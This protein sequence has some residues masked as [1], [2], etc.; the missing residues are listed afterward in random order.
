MIRRDVIAGGSY[1]EAFPDG[2]YYVLVGHD[3]VR[4][5]GEVVV[6]P[7]GADKPLYLRA[8]PSGQFAGQGHLSG[9]VIRY[10]N[11][12]WI[13]EGT[14]C[15]VNPVCF[16]P[17]GQLIVNTDCAMGTQGIRWIDPN[18]TLHS[19]DATYNGIGTTGVAEWTQLGNVVV[20]QSYVDGC[21]I[22]RVGDAPRT[23]EPG[24]CTFVRFNRVGSQL[25]VALWKQLENCA[26]LFWLDEADIATL[27]LEPTTTPQPQPEPEPD[28]Q[29]EPE[30]P[31]PPDNGVVNGVLV[32]PEHYFLTLV[33]GTRP[34]D[35]RTVLAQIEPALN[36]YGIGQ[37]KS[38]GGEPRGRLYLPTAI[39]PNAKPT[40]PQEQH[41]GVKQDPR[42]WEAQGRAVNVVAPDASQWIWQD[43]GGPAYQPIGTVPQPD[44][45]PQPQP[46][47]NPDLKV[48]RE[49][50]RSFKLDTNGH[51]DDLAVAIDDLVRRIT[52]LEQKPP[53]SLPADIVRE[54]THK[55]RVGPV[56]VF[57]VNAGTYDGTLV[58]K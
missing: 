43:M 47:P 38:S 20:G 36:L 29:P 2:S 25:A 32:N 28:P 42:C 48:L 10:Q 46:D 54:T 57:G 34:Q 44:P 13:A 26:V 45:N 22:R 51:F 49:E 53:Q 14:T 3:V 33:A 4:A 27:P 24:H 17:A 55:V 21:T 16:T 11:G 18:G 7:F 5:G 50:L 52:A 40:T 9:R 6:N 37:Q 56:R 8:H 15:G 19:G 30:P 12:Q 58:R 1:G 35:Y 23:L 31:V 41:L 39:C